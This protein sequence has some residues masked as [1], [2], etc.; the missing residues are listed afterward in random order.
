MVVSTLCELLGVPVRDPHL[1]K[2]ADLPEPLPT[3]TE[4]ISH[5]AGGVD[6]AEAWGA[7]DAAQR[8]GLLLRAHVCQLPGQDKPRIRECAAQS[9]LG[10]YT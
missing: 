9:R 3:F 6:R 1:T 8:R 5:E 4:L 10:S 2:A 7:Q